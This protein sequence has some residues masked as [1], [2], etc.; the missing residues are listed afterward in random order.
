MMGLARYIMFDGKEWDSNKEKWK[1]KYD[2]WTYILDA[3]FRG[4]L[5]RICKENETKVWEYIKKTTEE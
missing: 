5:P 1:P 2:A 4:F 3:N